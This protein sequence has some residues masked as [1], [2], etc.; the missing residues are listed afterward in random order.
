MLQRGIRSDQND[1]V[2]SADSAV[3][4][5]KAIEREMFSCCYCEAPLEAI[6]LET[7]EKTGE[8][9]LLWA[10]RNMKKNVCFFPMGLP[11]EIF[12]L[13]RSALEKEEG[14]IPKPDIRRLPKKFWGLYPTVFADQLQSKS[15]TSDTRAETSMSNHTTDYSSCPTNSPTTSGSSVSSDHAVF[16]QLLKMGS[17]TPVWGNS[18]SKS[19]R[20]NIV[21]HPHSSGASSSDKDDTEKSAVTNSTSTCSSTDANGNSGGGGGALAELI[22]DHLQYTGDDEL[23]SKMAGIVKKLHKEKPSRGKFPGN[24]THAEY[25]ASL[26]YLFNL[27][28]TPIKRKLNVRSADLPEAEKPTSGSADA[29]ANED[30]PFGA[31]EWYEGEDGPSTSVPIASHI[32]STSAEEERLN[33][34]VKDKVRSC[35]AKSAARRNEHRRRRMQESSIQSVQLNQQ[36]PSCGPPLPLHSNDLAPSEHF[37]EEDGL[38]SFDS[39]YADNLGEVGSALSFSHDDLIQQSHSTVVQDLSISDTTHFH[40]SSPNSDLDLHS[41]VG[42]DEFSNLFAGYNFM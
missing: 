7:D 10:C 9:R 1:D 33:A 41:P 20:R 28:V 38:L 4:R 26:D 21:G 24:F 23:V 32:D 34:I 39:P 30:D 19:K 27:D 36:Q 18:I 40:S 2:L 14:V 6:M 25:H 8:Q 15:R 22:C 31:K 37:N 29:T 13:K 17:E 12:F 35:I 11:S 5:E 16:D 3:Q 42:D